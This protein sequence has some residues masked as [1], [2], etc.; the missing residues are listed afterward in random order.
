LSVGA[1]LSDGEYE[2]IKVGRGVGV[3]LGEKVGRSVGSEVGELLLWRT[4]FV[5]WMLM[6]VIEIHV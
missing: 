3:K 2:G 1:S 4:R 6:P 5:L